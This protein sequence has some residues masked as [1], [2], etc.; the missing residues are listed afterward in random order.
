MPTLYDLVY[1]TASP[2][3]LAMLG[4][5]YA[6]RRKYHESLAGMLGRR[7]PRAVEPRPDGKRPRVFW[8]HSVSVGEVV[9]ARGVIRE[10]RAGY[11]DGRIYASTITETGQAHARRILADLVD[12][13]FYYPLDL[14]WIVRRFLDRI[15]PD[16]YI[17]MET[18]LWPNLLLRCRRAGVRVLMMNGKLSERSFRR[19]RQFQWFFRPALGGIDAFCM[20]TRLDAARMKELCGH[21]AQVFV[22]GNCK[23]DSVP[24]PLDPAQ[25]KALAARW[26]LDLLH[27][28]VVVGS[29]HPGEEEIVAQAAKALK[30]D[31]PGLTWLVAPRHVERA[32]AACQVFADAGLTISRARKPVMRRPDVL[33]LDVMG[34]LAQAYSLA[35][36]AVVCGSFVPVGGHNLLEPAVY[37]VPVLYGPHM[38]KQPELLRFFSESGG[39]VQ[40]EGRDLGPMVRRLLEDADERRRLGRLAAETIELNRGSAERHMR[41]LKHVLES[42]GPR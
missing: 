37:G 38:H 24:A 23:F 1:L 13:V 29:T 31:F 28:M 7:M 40:V 17:M 21:G 10:I 22:T 9:A 27:P 15:R 33:V 36:V 14:S 32:D 3:L 26:G 35:T 6:F 42:R 41:V 25:R 11:P 12:E 39:G 30:A 16:V 5:R 4:Y 20:Q 34:E 19:Y 18:E 8:V 2:A